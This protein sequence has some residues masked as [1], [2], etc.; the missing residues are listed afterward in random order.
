ML[1]QYITFSIRNLKKEKYYSILNI[2]GLTIGLTAFLLLISYVIHESS[3][4]NYHSKAD[5]IYRI[6]Q[7]GLF[8]HDNPSTRTAFMPFPLANVLRKEF[9]EVE[10]V[11]QCSNRGG[12]LI[13]TEDMK[14]VQ[15]WND[16]SSDSLLFEMFDFEILEGDPQTALTEPYTVV[17]SR[18]LSKKLFGNENPIGKL[19]RLDSDSTMFRIT[20]L[21]ETPRTNSH[22]RPNIVSCLQPRFTD[23]WARNGMFTYVRLK[24]GASVTEFEKKL[25]G[26]VTKYYKPAIE[27]VFN[28]PYDE[29]YVGRKLQYFAMNIKYLHLN[30]NV[31]F[32]VCGKSGNASIIYIYL[33]IALALLVLICINY[34]NLTTSRSVTRMKEI[35]IRKAHG[36]T[37]QSLILQLVIESVIT[38]L[39]AVFFSAIFT[40]LLIPEFCKLTQLQ[41]EVPFFSKTWLVPCLIAFSV[42]LGIISGLYPA[43]LMSNFDAIE[44]LKT[45]NKNVGGGVLLRKALVVSQLAISFVILTAAILT[46]RQFNYMMEKDWGYNKDNLITVQGCLELGNNQKAFKEAILQNPD[47]VSATFAV[48]PLFNNSMFSTHTKYKD[49]SNAKYLSTLVFAD[50][51]FVKT[52]QIEL[53]QGRT[54]QYGNPGEEYKCVINETAA[55]TYGFDNPVGQLLANR[56]DTLPP[57]EIVG[58]VKDFNFKSLSEEIQPFELALAVKFNPNT[59]FIRTTGNNIPQV[60]E[61]IKTTWNKFNHVRGMQ[62]DI[63]DDTIKWYYRNELSSKQT[64]FYFSI[65]VIVLACLGLIGLISYSTLRRRKEIAVRKV[66]GATTLQIMM[67]LSKSTV[68][69]LVISFAIGIPVSYYL[70]KSWLDGFAYHIELSP[71]LFVYSATL[72]FIISIAT[73][74]LV[75]QN[76]ARRNPALALKEE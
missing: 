1:K 61:H 45:K 54:L 67:M 71:M 65:T 2:A 24:E 29:I 47:I 37:K 48:N 42:L 38:V 19:L 32:E 26:L 20:A 63:F 56:L 70:A 52:M 8:F 66:N 35:A 41:I 34:I 39:L 62:Y 55:K 9:P 75:S 51:D 69:F 22:F 31:N 13:T 11:H 58:V 33:A 5:R 60:I 21:Y 72:L 49:T 74:I 10:M 59:C 64:L 57:I 18:E 76:A 6:H 4:D 14:E 12:T 73:E 44:G 50:E 17:I 3:Y 30:A 25:A 68:V 16:M 53:V 36:A 40:Q 46:S 28:K 15:E 43:W 7:Q 23:N 27:K